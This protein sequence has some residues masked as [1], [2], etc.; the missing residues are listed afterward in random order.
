MPGRR[1]CR[2]GHRRSVDAIATY[3][4]PVRLGQTV[5]D[6][7]LFLAPMA[8]G[9]ELPFRRICRRYGAG[10]V[11]TE[12]VTARGIRYARGV[13]KNFRYLEISP[14]EFPV[15]IQFFGS[16]PEDF[17]YAISAVF[18]H[19]LLSRC[20]AIDINMGCPVPKVVKTGA[21]CALMGDPERASR[22]IRAA[23]RVSP[24]PVTVKF[25]SGLGADSVN[26]EPFGA[27]CESCGA[28][29]LTVHPR[30]AKQMYSG[31]ADWSVIGRVKRA[32]GIPVIGNGD[33]TGPADAARMFR[34]TGA[35]GIMIGRAALGDPWIF[36]A[37]LRALSGGEENAADTIDAVEAADA[38]PL[39][40]RFP[41]PSM[42]ERLRVVREH[43]AGS[44]AFMGEATAMKEMRKHFSWYFK[45]IP[46]GSAIRSALVRCETQAEAEAIL[47]SL[48]SGQT[49][50]Y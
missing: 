45:G 47:D 16:E 2:P 6:N 42:E 7:N 34:E 40:N 30:T 48:E 8:G 11:F 32:S 19:P 46:N 1:G 20:A 4:R 25:R 10:L 23:V 38:E 22:I 24:V 26:A 50:G 18:G 27:M 36:A 15:A 9:S 14:D 3:I 41:P 37:I 39:A 49:F 33:V 35:D 12:L 44:I 28:S 43:L 17:E 21:G 31:R 5:I 13:E 29:M